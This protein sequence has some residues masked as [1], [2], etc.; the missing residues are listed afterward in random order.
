[1]TIKRNSAKA[2]GRAFQKEIAEILKEAYQLED[3]D[4]VSTPASVPGEDILMSKLAKKRIPFSIECKNQ[5]TTMIWQCI[6]QCED[7]TPKG[8]IPLIVFKRNR[9]DI[10]CVMKFKDLLGLDLGW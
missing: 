9:S 3:R 8:R 5:E 7:N 10:Y 4:V 1:M 6:K 2:K